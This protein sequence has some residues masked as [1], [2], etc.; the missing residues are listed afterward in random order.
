M[1]LAYHAYDNG[2]FITAFKEF[3]KLAY[4]GNAVA[5]YNLAFMY[6]GEK[7]AGQNYSEAFYWFMKAAKSGHVSAQDILCLY[8]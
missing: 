1:S 2:D 4:E 7:G 5:Q 3:T 6:Y 8:V